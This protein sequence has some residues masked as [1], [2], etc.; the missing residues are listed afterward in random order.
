MV[1]NM[2]NRI[3]I[4]LYKWG[5]IKYAQQMHDSIAQNNSIVQVRV[6]KVC[7]TEVW[8][9]YTV[10]NGIILSLC[11]CIFFFCFLMVWQIGMRNENNLCI[12]SNLIEMSTIY[13][14]THSYI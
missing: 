4:L 8:L 3:M 11:I 13:R 2:H 1:Q 14:D 5:S 6:N 9:Y 7:T 10:Y 12:K